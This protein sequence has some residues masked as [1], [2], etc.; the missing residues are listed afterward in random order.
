MSYRQEDMKHD[1]LD[2]APDSEPDRTQST[3]SNRASSAQQ[4]PALQPHQEPT[5]IRQRSPRRREHLPQSWVDTQQA[6]SKNSPHPANLRS[7]P[8]LA[9]INSTSA[10]P[11]QSSSP[12]H[13]FSHAGSS[14]LEQRLSSI[15][16]T[17]SP[18]T[19]PSAAPTKRPSPVPGGPSS[20]SRGFAVPGAFPAEGG[21][22]A[23][24]DGEG[25]QD[26][27]INSED[28]RE[29]DPISR[30]RL[31]HDPKYF[32]EKRKEREEAAKRGKGADK[33]E[34]PPVLGGAKGGGTAGGG[35]AS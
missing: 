3:P 8:A 17:S 26:V 6:Q 24:K 5:V 9:P 29:W 21:D 27:K 22:S 1:P 13:G 18:P 11:A 15:A 2:E 33:K 25:F 28:E 4:S 34:A 20:Q 30:Y 31:G 14:S 7:R 10:G 23:P 32:E 12:G 35:V 19:S 16:A